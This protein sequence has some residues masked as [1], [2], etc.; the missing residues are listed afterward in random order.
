MERLWLV[1]VVAIR[2]ADLIGVQVLLCAPG[3]AVPLL[4]IASI[5]TG[6]GIRSVGHLKLGPSFKR[7]HVVTITP[8]R[9]VM[10]LRVE[11]RRPHRCRGIIGWMEIGGGV[12]H[13]SCAVTST[14]CLKCL[15]V[16][17]DEGR[18]EASG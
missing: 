9:V 8:D 1:K 14:P 11:E 12:T 10:L 16:L 5:P 17:W 4:A 13:C 15:V 3:R 18:V 2:C 7:L 6:S